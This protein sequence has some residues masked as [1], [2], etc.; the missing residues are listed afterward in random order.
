MAN[1]NNPH[2]H[3]PKKK[4][5]NNNKKKKGKSLAQDEA[6]KMPI[7]GNTKQETCTNLISKQHAQSQTKNEREESRQS[8]ENSEENWNIESQKK[9]NKKQQQ[10]QMMKG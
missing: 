3:W 7:N 6:G 8:R 5:I 9:K 2:K 1:E 10:K 4:K